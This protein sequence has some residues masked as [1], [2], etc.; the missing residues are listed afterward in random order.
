M[1]LFLSRHVPKKTIRH[2]WL[3]TFQTS[4]RPNITIVDGTK[5]ASASLK[6][7]CVA[8]GNTY[9]ARSLPRPT[10]HRASVCHMERSGAQKEP[11]SAAAASSARSGRSFRR[12]RRQITLEIVPRHCALPPKFG[13][14]YYCAARPP[15]DRTAYC[16]RS[17]ADIQIA[18]SIESHV[19]NR[20]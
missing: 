3:C 13:A 11:A 19:D 17:F 18:V 10:T 14:A 2:E 7:T 20:E 4:Q 1:G 8:G 16:P 9:Q 15:L 12:G 5:A 6:P